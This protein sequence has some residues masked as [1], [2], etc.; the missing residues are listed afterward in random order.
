MSHLPKDPELALTLYQTPPTSYLHRQLEIPSWV[1][2][3]GSSLIDVP[4]RKQLLHVPESMWRQAE[5]AVK[6]EKHC[7]VTRLLHYCF[8]GVRVQ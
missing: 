5:Y 2:Q 6:R 4:L 3:F 8:Y 1:T 7:I